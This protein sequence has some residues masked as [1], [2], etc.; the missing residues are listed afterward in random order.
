MPQSTKLESFGDEAQEAETLTI[1]TV[2]CVSILLWISAFS[3][4]NIHRD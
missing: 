2:L 3:T 1:W 4:E